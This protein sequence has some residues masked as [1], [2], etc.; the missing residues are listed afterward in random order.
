MDGAG[1]RR[2]ACCVTDKEKLPE[3]VWGDDAYSWTTLQKPRSI[4]GTT[5]KEVD[6]GGGGG[7]G[8]WWVVV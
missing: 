2:G 1:G 8:E 6:H 7:G 4:G 3:D 5:S